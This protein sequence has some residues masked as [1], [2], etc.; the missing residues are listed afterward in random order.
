VYLP[1]VEAATEAAE[2]PEDGRVPRGGAESILL[3]EDEAN[4]RDLALEILQMRGYRVLVAGDP[5]EAERVA[6]AHAGPINLLLT[7]VIM[8]H[9]SGRQLAER[10]V[11]RRPTMRVLYTSGYT[12]D[13]LAHHGVLGP[14]IFFLQ[15]PYSPSGLARMVREV[16]DTPA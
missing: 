12:D 11:A 8:A 1:R 9:M 15:K 7:D 14:E 4:L 3:V 16:L 10:L 2:R 13:A 5:L 6:D